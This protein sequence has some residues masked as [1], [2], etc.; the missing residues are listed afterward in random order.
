MLPVLVCEGKMHHAM[1]AGKK[2][3]FLFFFTTLS[4]AH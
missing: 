1:K 3:A 2:L 4:S